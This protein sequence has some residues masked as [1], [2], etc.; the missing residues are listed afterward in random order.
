MQIY[1]LVVWFRDLF[2]SRPMIAENSGD[3]V[4]TGVLPLP[5]AVLP[6]YLPLM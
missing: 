2:Y 4:V 3:I 5:K 6:R 1:T